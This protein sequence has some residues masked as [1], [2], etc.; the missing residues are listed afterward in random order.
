MMADDRSG[1]RTAWRKHDR[2]WGG[3]RYV[4]AVVSRRSGGISIGINLNP[5]KACNFDCIYCQVDRVT[6]PALRKVDLGIIEQELYRLL[7]S[8][9]SGE[10]YATSPFDLMAN[11]HRGI[12]D[13]AFSGDGE[14]TSYPGFEEAVRITANAR[15]H[16][17]LETAKLVLITDAA[18][19]A[20]PS[21][22]SA[23]ELLHADNGE[24]WAKLDAG[25]D[26]Y[27]QMVNR[28]NVPFRKVLDNILDAARNHPLVIQTLWMRIRG[29][30]PPDSEIDAYCRR[31]NDLLE[32]GAQLKAL[33][34]YT[35]AR[36]PAE[37]YVGPLSDAELDNIAA[38]VRK[39]V[40]VPVQTYYGVK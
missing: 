21:V 40:A 7:E 12:R 28:P 16:F 9:R 33:Q 26:T 23:L 22:R 27:Y 30:I 29:Q 19:L 2:K 1:I 3:N 31:I 5:S 17:G 25:T 8:E 36:D 20:R 15:R 18:Y 13:I 10:L 11:G 6:P 35:I 4:Y 14:P 34:L 39:A 38:T 24:I 32:N 37:S